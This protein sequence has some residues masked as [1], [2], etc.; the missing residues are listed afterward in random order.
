M[1]T[2]SASGYPHIMMQNQKDKKKTKPEIEISSIKDILSNS[3][4]AHIDIIGNKAMISEI[5]KFKETTSIISPTYTGHLTPSASGLFYNSIGNELIGS[6][7]GSVIMKDRFELLATAQNNINNTVLRLGSTAESTLGSIGTSIIKDLNNSFNTIHNTL[8]TSGAWD[9][10]VYY[11]FNKSPLMS[12][13]STATDVLQHTQNKIG[14][15]LIDLSKG[16]L[17]THHFSSS[18]LTPL[19]IST[20]GIDALVDSTKL[21]FFMTATEKEESKKEE[22]LS[23]LEEEMEQIK[24][25]REIKEITRV[26][27]EIEK[28]LNGLD[29]ELITMFIGGH[30][31]FADEKKIDRIRQSSISMR[32]LVEKLP[33]YLISKDYTYESKKTIDKKSEAIKV[34]LIDSKDH[35]HEEVEFICSQQSYLYNAFSQLEHG[36]LLLREYSKNPKLYDALLSQIEVWLIMIKNKNV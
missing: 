6:T 1:N 10:P 17:N 18:L 5:N 26:N 32:G 36:N 29:K 3:E 31:T 27:K 11:D 25:D 33:D 21:S 30:Q 34:Y 14:V 13:L 35:T 8:I 22:R 24:K 9:K 19:K 23:A 20:G 12:T 7:G 16:T 15:A 4:L 2:E 28:W